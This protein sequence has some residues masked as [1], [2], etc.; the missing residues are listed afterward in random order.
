MALAMQDRAI[1]TPRPNISSAS[2]PAQGSKTKRIT[3]IHLLVEPFDLGHFNLDTLTH[4]ETVPLVLR[5]G[6]IDG[7]GL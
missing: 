4:G 7:I 2:A 5:L 3:A 6:R 1:E